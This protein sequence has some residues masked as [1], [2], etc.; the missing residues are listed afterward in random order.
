[1]KETLHKKQRALVKELIANS[2]LKKTHVA[3]KIGVSPQTLS[4]I[5][6]GRRAIKN[7]ELDVLCV[8]LGVPKKHITEC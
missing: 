3:S 7:D 1:M 8:T 4:H 5:L 6:N 2:G